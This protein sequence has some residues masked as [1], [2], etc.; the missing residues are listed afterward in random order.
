M[1]WCSVWKYNNAVASI[2]GLL[3]YSEIKIENLIQK[4]SNGG[5]GLGK[6]ASLCLGAVLLWD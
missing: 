1:Q 2:I 4:Q 6:Q 5:L 3:S